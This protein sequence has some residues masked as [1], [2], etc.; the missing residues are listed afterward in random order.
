ME[1]HIKMTSHNPMEKWLR[2][3]GVFVLIGLL[4]EMAALRWVHPSAFLVFAFVG[5]PLALL[6]TVIYLYALVSL[7]RQTK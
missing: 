1:R 6:G 7:Q 3:A 2:I 4:V 5:I